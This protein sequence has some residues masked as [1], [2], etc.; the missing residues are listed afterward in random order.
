MKEFF[1]TCCFFVWSTLGFSQ[2]GFPQAFIGHWQG[3]LLWYKTGK[4]VPQKVKMQLVIQPTDTSNVYTWQIIYGKKNEDNRPYLLKPVDTA[5][6][7]WQ[8]DERNGIIL[9]QYFVGN[10]FTSAFTVQSTTIVDSYWR[11]G[12]NL[13]AEFY[14]L[15]AKPVATTGLGTEESPNV[16]SY[17]TRGYQRAVLKQASVSSKQG[18]RK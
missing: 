4:K 11:E 10:R 15:T 13:I 1:L 5:Q 2:S 14:S 8:V 17:G 6:G 3:E 7:H 9:D 18:R 16:D 12:K